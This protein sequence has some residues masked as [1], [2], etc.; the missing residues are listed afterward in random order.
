MKIRP[1]VFF[2]NPIEG[3][4]KFRQPSRYIEQKEDDDVKNYRPMRDDFR[5]CR[6]NFFTDRTTRIKN[7]NRNLNVPA[8]L[9][10][11]EIHFF[12][13]FNSFKFEN[14]YRT[15]YGLASVYFK[16]YNGTGVFAIIERDLFK[17]FI[18]QLDIFI[19][20]ADNRDNPEVDKHILFIR[21]FYFLSTERIIQYLELKSYVVI[22]LIKNPELFRSF[23]LPVE[24][25]L[26][27]YLKENGIEFYLREND[28]Q[29]ELIDVSAVV[30]TEIADNFDII[31]SV[32]SYSAGIVRPS[33]YNTPFKEYGFTIANADENLP[34]IGIIDTGISNNTPLAPIIIN[35]GNEYNL[36]G[37]SVLLDEANHGSAV[38][39]FA[40]LGTHLIPNHI[41][42]FEADARL[43]PIKTMNSSSGSVKISDVERLIRQ[44]NAEYQCKIFTLTILFDHPLKNN[45]SISEYAYMLDRLAF[46]LDIIVFISSGNNFEL[47]EGL[48][49]PKPINYPSHFIESGRNICSPADS[50]NNIVVG[51]ISD[52]FEFNGAG[53]L[54]TDISF[55]ASYTRKFNFEIND[56]IKNS[57]RISKHLSKPDFVMPGGDVDNS[58]S[59]EET[60]I[61]VLSTRTGFFFDRECGTSYSA[62]LA[63][64]LAAKIVRVYPKLSGNMQSVKALIINAANE[65]NLGNVFNQ[66]KINPAKLIGKGIPDVENV[67]Y[68]NEN[69]ITFLLEDNISPDQIQ[70][71]PLRIPEYLQYL[72]HKLSVLKITATICYKFKPVQES[73]ISYCPVLVSFGVFGNNEINNSSS[74]EYKI[75][76][77]ESWSEDYYYGTKLLSNC[78]KISF[79][80]KKESLAN[81]DFLLKLAVNCRLHKLLSINQKRELTMNYS[82]SIAINITELPYKGDLSGNLYSE[83]E[84][85]NYLESIADLEANLEV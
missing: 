76:G 56:I 70:I 1:H 10:Y 77:G 34:V 51:A 65:P 26:T 7:R 81:E 50:R 58:I 48:L 25:A 67:L 52:N 85:I 32:N 42:Q 61:K 57:R 78:Q 31:H 80:I 39:L 3:R 4:D 28:D 73:H 74:V 22:N 17:Y 11:I 14:V 40:T 63:A 83:L 15:R 19:N 30:L 5:R 8:H 66:V 69:S 21:E 38:A 16:N 79:N 43:L 18:S 27:N 75:K 41:G 13:A 49:N 37:S 59:S 72:N 82:F 46:E 47:T 2:R 24:S 6:D 12:D 54:S 55:P 29:I 68:S 20:T 23:T 45:E 62:P 64:N 33:L 60:G 84:A 71:Y 36:T 53:V 9:E 44:A 35:S